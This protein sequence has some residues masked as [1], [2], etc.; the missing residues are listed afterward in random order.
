MKR[1]FWLFAPILLLA[2]TDD[3]AGDES[4]VDPLP[5]STASVQGFVPDGWYLERSVV[6]DLNADGLSD[7][8]LIMRQNDPKLL[9]DNEGLGRDRY[10]SN[11]RTILVALKQSDGG[12]LRIAHNDQIIPV[13][14]SATMDDPI[15]DA[16]DGS[17]SLV[18][19]VMR[20]RI[21]F[22]ASA[23]AWQMFNRTFSF[24][25]NDRRLRLIGYDNYYVHRGSGELKTTS[26]NYLTR[27]K[28]SQNGSI[29][30]THVPEVWSKISR[31]PLIL[32]DN[33]G[34]GF[35]FDPDR[36]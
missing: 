12:Y 19:G 2:N 18:K 24:R 8:V 32:F 15:G 29:E 9:I 7:I 28:K 11:P 27:R 23:G 1:G 30:D 4:R 22:W 14:S 5:L 33:I 36:N 34:D 13:I 25:L 31:K 6:G 16:G 26:I 20:L 10:D 17:L 35:D 21:G 3:L